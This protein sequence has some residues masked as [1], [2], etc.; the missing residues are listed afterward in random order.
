MS[1]SNEPGAPL[2]KAKEAKE[3]EANADRLQ[4]LGGGKDKKRNSS[5]ASTK[6]RLSK[7][8]HGIKDFPKG[9]KDTELAE[10]KVQVITVFPWRN[11]LLFFFHVYYKK[12]LF[13]KHH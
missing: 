12:C 2:K 10:V 4:A 13:K 8:L 11:L 9:K 6:K 1:D 5:S 3:N 7:E